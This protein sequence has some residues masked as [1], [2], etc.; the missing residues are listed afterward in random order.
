MDARFQDFTVVELKSMSF[1]VLV[2]VGLVCYHFRT[3]Y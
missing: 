1:W 3:G 2:Q